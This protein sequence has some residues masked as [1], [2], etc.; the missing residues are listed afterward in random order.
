[1][2]GQHDKSF[3]GEQPSQPQTNPY[4][5]NCAV[6]QDPEP[7]K[8]HRFFGVLEESGSTWDAGSSGLS[9][10]TSDPYNEMGE[11]DARVV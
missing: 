11:S 7:A 5:E 3:E 4:V 9:Q 8:P 6:P 1:M 2:S 10:K